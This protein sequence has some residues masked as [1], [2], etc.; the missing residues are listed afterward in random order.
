[1]EEIT[2]ILVLVV[3]GV[4]ATWNAIYSH[5]YSKNNIMKNLKEY[6]KKEKA[7]QQKSKVSAN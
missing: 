1:M 2:I 4:F 5:H 6:D 7:K 3:M